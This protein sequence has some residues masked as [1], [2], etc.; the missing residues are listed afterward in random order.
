MRF[1]VCSLD[2]HTA[3]IYNAMVS[4][5]EGLLIAI[6]VHTGETFEPVSLSP[7]VNVW[8]SKPWVL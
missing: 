5:C 8:M 2:G 7:D 6:T 1:D 3:V 4:N